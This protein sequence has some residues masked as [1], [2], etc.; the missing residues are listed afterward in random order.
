MLYTDEHTEGRT[1]EDRVEWR[2]GGMHG[3]KQTSMQACMQAGKQADYFAALDYFEASFVI[4]K[5]CGAFQSSDTW[6]WVN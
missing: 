2:Q 4:G 6:N 5:E 1:E 3:C